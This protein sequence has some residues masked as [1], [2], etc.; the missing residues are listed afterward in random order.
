MKKGND[1]SGIYYFTNIINNKVYIG[2]SVTIHNRKLGHLNDL[3][4]NRHVNM[5]FQRA[6]NKYGEEN[7]IH[8]ILAKCP[9]EYLDRM[10]NKFVKLFNASNRKFGYNIRT[11]ENKFPVESIVKLKKSLKNNEKV[12]AARIEMWKTRK[13]NKINQYDLQGNFVKT[14]TSTSE[15]SK[16]LKIHQSLIRKVCTGNYGLYSIKQFM[17]RDYINTDNINP[18]TSIRV[19]KIKIVSRTIK[20]VNCYDKITKEL[21]ATYKNGTDAAILLGLDSSCISKCCKD[22]IKYYKKYIFKYI[23]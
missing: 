19:K 18:C 12:I 4:N 13:R 16:T 17:F 1:I 14:W 6:F 7:F 2:K 21:L 15:A 22:K 9:R 11:E 23:E 10:E 8:N 5:H 3:R 20:K